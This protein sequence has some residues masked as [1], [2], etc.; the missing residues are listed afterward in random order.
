[1]DISRF[2]TVLISVVIFFLKVK[3]ESIV[4]DETYEAIIDQIIEQIN[5]GEYG[6]GKI[7]RL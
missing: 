3:V 5:T 6:D 1:M 7:F 2:T 4:S